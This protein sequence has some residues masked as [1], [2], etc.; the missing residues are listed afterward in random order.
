MPILVLPKLS[1][2]GSFASLKKPVDIF[3]YVPHYT[4]IGRFS[5]MHMLLH[6]EGF[7][8]NACLEMFPRL[9]TDWSLHII[10]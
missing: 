3:K 9:D 7:P 1:K 4:A 6:F 8:G 5:V 10:R 2:L